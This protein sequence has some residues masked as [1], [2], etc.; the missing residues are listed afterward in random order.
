MLPVRP[1]PGMREQ[2]L[3][4][5]LVPPRPYT[6]PDAP[7]YLLADTGLLVGVGERLV[8]VKGGRVS[9][10]VDLVLRPMCELFR[11]TPLRSGAPTELN[12]VCRRAEP[13]DPGPA[14]ACISG[15]VMVYLRSSSAFSCEHEKKKQARR[16]ENPDAQLGR[17]L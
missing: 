10:P 3:I 11:E 7:R 14:K 6:F 2:S 15:H 16:D 12:H 9:A 5:V 4:P 13:P 1:P 17:F 8:V